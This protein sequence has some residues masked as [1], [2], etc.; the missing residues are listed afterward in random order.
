M[1]E[2]LP[3]APATAINRQLARQLAEQVDPEPRACWRNSTLSMACVRDQSELFYVEGWLLTEDRQF[4]IEHGWLTYRG[5][6]VDVSSNGDDEADCYYGVWQYNFEA[7]LRLS[8]QRGT[9]PFYARTKKRRA[10]M[11]ARFEE[12]PVEPHVAV[13]FARLAEFFTGIRMIYLEVADAEGRHY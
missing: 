6:V 10:A 7:V 3:N 4:P 12:L 5:E 1:I 9:L 8:G 13:A 11:L 2:L